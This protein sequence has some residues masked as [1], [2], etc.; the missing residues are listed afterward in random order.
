MR[1]NSFTICA[2]VTIDANLS[3]IF[4]SFFIKYPNKVE[5]SVC[6]YCEQSSPNIDRHYFPIV[7]IRP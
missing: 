5:N 2:P 6:K 1:K 7:Y 3:L 4:C